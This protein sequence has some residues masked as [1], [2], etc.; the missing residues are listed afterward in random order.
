MAI[1]ERES[2]RTTTV[3]QLETLADL[4][5]SNAAASVTFNDKKTAEE[6]LVALQA[7]HHILAASIYDDKGR[8]F[9]T[10]RRSD[11]TADF[12]VPDWNGIGAHFSPQ[13]I[14]LTRKVSLN[15]EGIGFIVI[16]SDLSEFQAK[17]REYGQISLLVL[18]VSV[19][20]TYLASSKLLRVV[21]DPIVELADVAGKV[22]AEQDYSLRAVPR[23]SDEAG[24]LVNSFI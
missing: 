1:Y 8:L 22:S 20:I 21:S 24:R 15:G 11:L 17:L 13:S 5:G 14:T 18:F 6:L 23:S 2:F 16:L 3:T 10:Y 7:E 9:A 19:L 4:L 12:K